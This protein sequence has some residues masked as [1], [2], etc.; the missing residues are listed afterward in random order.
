[1]LIDF[2]ENMIKQYSDLFFKN[3]GK[4]EVLNKYLEY[5]KQRNA[6]IEELFTYI[7]NQDFFNK[8]IKNTTLALFNLY[9]LYVI[10]SFEDLKA[11]YKKINGDLDV[12]LDSFEITNEF[13]NN[14]KALTVYN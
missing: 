8:S 9:F 11:D 6:N 3:G 13:K 4:E 5:N 10:Q 12:A 7:V 1:M 2:H 14:A